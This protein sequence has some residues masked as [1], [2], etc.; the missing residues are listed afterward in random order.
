MFLERITIASSAQDQTSTSDNSSSFKLGDALE[1]T[2]DAVAA[3]GILATTADGLQVCL[4]GFGDLAQGLV[5]GAVL[6]LRVLAV[7]PRLELALLDTAVHSGGISSG[8]AMN[9]DDFIQ[10]AAMRFDQ[11]ALACQVTPALPGAVSIAA[12]W[13]AIAL[14]QL[15]KHGALPGKVVELHMPARL[16]AENGVTRSGRIRD[17]GQWPFAPDGYGSFRAMLTVLDAEEDNSASKQKWKSRRAVIALLLESILPDIG[18]IVLRMRLASG[19]VVLDVYCEEKAKELAYK[20]Q[21][22]IISAIARAGLRVSRCRRI[23][24]LLA[25]VSGNTSSG[26]ASL[27]SD[28]SSELA[29]P[30]PLFRAAAEVLLLLS[31]P[32]LPARI[33]R[34][35]R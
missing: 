24:N 1:L 16:L 4:S 30:L 21:P 13:R 34:S 26:V 9:A 7:T 27:Q 15:E 35:Y 32:S 11:L 18:R 5:P 12:S 14:N 19:S 25:G 28:V 17:A 22:D 23:R 20:L 2:F 33:S 8:V 29:L 10:T 6:N 3:D 31:S